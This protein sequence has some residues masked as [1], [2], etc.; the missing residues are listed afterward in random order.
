MDLAVDLE[1]SGT[2]PSDRAFRPD[3]QGLRAV[4]VGIVVLYHFGGGLQL[5]PGG[6]IGV[7]VFFVISGFVIT[8]LLLRERRSH[9]A[10][11]LLDFYARRARRIIPAVTLV[12]LMTV[13]A[14]YHWLGALRGNEVAGDGRWSAVFL[15]NFHFIAQGTNYFQ[16]LVPP[17]PLLHLWSLAV[18][19]Q[20]YLA[21][22]LVFLLLVGLSPRGRWR[23]SLVAGLIVIAAA[24]F[25]L[26]VVQTTGDPTVAYFSPFTRAWE[27]TA[28][29]LLAVLAPRLGR[30]RPRRGALLSWLGLGV[31]LG[32]ALSL[33]AD[34]PFPGV[35]AL[36]PVV[37]ASLVIVGGLVAPPR[38]G[39]ELVLGSWIGLR[40]GEISYS[41]YLW[42][43]PVI[44]IAEQQISSRLHLAQ[45]AG[46]LVVSI[47]LA[48][49]STFL[50]E[51][52]IRHA[53]RLR[54]SRALSLGLG[55]SLIALVLIVC[56][57]LLVDHSAARNSGRLPGPAHPN[58]AQIERE[59]ARAATSSR[60]PDPMAP[61]LLDVPATPLHPPSIPDRCIADSAA[62]PWVP[63]CVFGDRSS[64]HTLVLLGDSQ[65][66]AWSGAVLEVA[67]AEHLRLV[68]VAMNGCQPWYLPVG[69]TA[70]ERS[71]A[72]FRKRSL[73]RVAAVHPSTILLAGNEAHGFTAAQN[74][75]GLA[76]LL[77]A[78]SPIGAQVT[79]LGPIPWFAGAYTGPPPAEC[80]AR[81]GD[82]LGRCALSVATLRRSFG[83]FVV[84]MRSAAER[85]EANYL[86]VDRLFCTSS[87]CP[88]AIAH[89]FVYQDRVHT[90][91]Q[92]SSYVGRGLDALLRPLLPA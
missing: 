24:S 36:I 23:S 63:L 61:S 38:R 85:H 35:A 58:L 57:V 14:T 77:D 29:A 4:A 54:T 83:G 46:L 44:I 51:N 76:R 62:T 68:I 10:S 25:V 41:L 2:P 48:V 1:D 8:G 65:A 72:S 86:P 11:V 47:A 32:G 3:I 30:V 40:G 49:A 45:R 84:A 50:I 22:P 37:G 28:G 67:K 55:A 33:S 82:D 21:F 20:F 17:S 88:V 60:L 26:S 34:T 9:R 7:D 70:G 13:F 16:A 90:T 92:Y 81:F 52:P 78:L 74:A 42:H 71:C 75:S 79:V 15:A 27:L 31:I 87:T 56:S 91:W 73:A 89:R 53:R 6:F 12:I 64:R 19:E 66:N 18:E 69:T 59:V 43:F 39:A 80:A 5:F